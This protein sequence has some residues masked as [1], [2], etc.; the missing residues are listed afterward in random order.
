MT[1][2]LTRY[3]LSAYKKNLNSK[4]DIVDFDLGFVDD[5]IAIQKSENIIRKFHSNDV[6]C[7][8]VWDCTNNK[9]I[10]V[11]NLWDVKYNIY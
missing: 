4:T 2:T 3:K 10:Q 8:R 9:L 5:Y 6:K 7:Y 11:I 1:T